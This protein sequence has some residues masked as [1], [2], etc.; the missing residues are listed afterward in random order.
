M[1]AVV[2]EEL[3][4]PENLRYMDIPNPSLCSGQ[5]LID[6]KAVGVNFPDNL[7]IQGLYQEKPTLPFVPGMELSGVVAGVADD[8]T[9]FDVG[10]RVLSTTGTGAYCEQVAVEKHRCIGMPDSLDFNKAAALMCVYGTSIHALKQRGNLQAGENLL[11]LGA[12]GGVGLSAVQIG[13]AMGARVIAAASSEQK[14][15]LAKANGAD[16]LVNYGSGDL[17]D[18]VKALT[19]GKGAD[20]I[21][22]PVGGELFDQSVRCINFN[23]RLLIIG[24]ASGTIPKL[25]AGLALVKGM[26]AVGVFWGRF[27]TKEQPELHA[28]NMQILF[29]WLELGVIEPHIDAAMPLSQAAQA[30]R[31]IADRKVQG[32]LVLTP[33]G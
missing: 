4:A 12:A 2:C 3:G 16:E 22:D 23:G 11:V 8:V 28:E 30:L 1:K 25:Q 31:K 27:A 14:L 32:K 6:V 10:D 33:G 9:E 20:V 5:V 17:K 19:A 7:I 24:F 21:Y 15:A 18:Q 13:K 26:S 29:D